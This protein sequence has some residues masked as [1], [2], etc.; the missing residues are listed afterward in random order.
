M[1]PYFDI[2]IK[3]QYRMHLKN[4]KV[5]AMQNCKLWAFWCGK[6]TPGKTQRPTHFHLHVELPTEKFPMRVFTLKALRI[7]QL[8]KFGETFGWKNNGVNKNHAYFSRYTRYSI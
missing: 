1:A 5:K 6:L 3:Q 7:L 4:L 2:T 8:L